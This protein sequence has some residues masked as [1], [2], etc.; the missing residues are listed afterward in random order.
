MVSPVM[1][2]EDFSTPK[3]APQRPKRNVHPGILQ[4][5]A[6]THPDKDKDLRHDMSEFITFR[7]S[8]ESKVS[9]NREVYDKHTALMGNAVHQLTINAMFSKMDD[10]Q[11]RRKQG[12]Q[13]SSGGRGHGKGGRG[14]GRGGRGTSNSG[15]GNGGR[16]YG[17]ANGN[18]GRTGTRYEPYS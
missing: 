14:Q 4:L 12:Q 3:D 6:D 9:E 8:M 13:N 1:D 5:L 17:K 16:G 15:R 10:I 7:L 18:V 2:T 11:H